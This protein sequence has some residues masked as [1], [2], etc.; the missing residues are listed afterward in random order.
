MKKTTYPCSK[1][2]TDLRN[3]YLE[4]EPRFRKL[5]D[6][7]RKHRALMLYLE[8]WRRCKANP[9][10]ATT[11]LRKSYAE[12]YM[13]ENTVPNI[14][15][16]ELIVGKPDLRD[17]TPE[18]TELFAKYME[19]NEFVV[20][21]WGRKDH[22]A[23]DYQLLLDEGV[24]G[25]LEILK[26]E[27]EKIN[28][29]DGMQ[30]ERYEFLLC[31]KIELEGVVKLSEAYADRALEMAESLVGEE[32][33]EMMELYRVLKQVPANPARTF[34][35]ALQSIQMFTFNLYGLYSYGKPDLYLYPYYARDIENGVLTP[36]KAQEL[37]DCFY[38]LSVPNCPSWAAMGLM[39]GGRDRE[40]NSI[41]N[42]LTWHFLNAIE[43]TGVPDPNIGFCV[44]EETGKEILEYVAEIISK[45]YAQPQIWNTD[46]VIESMVANG[47]DRK[48]ANL[49][50][51]STCVEVTP[52]GCSGINVTSP[53]INVLKV[54]LDSF[55]KCDN[56]MSFDD[57]F[58][59]FA[60]C[61][62]DFCR[63][64]VT[65]ENLYLLEQGRNSTD[66]VRCSLLIHDCLERGKTHD[67][68]GA[69]YNQLE[70]DLFGI[71]NVGESLNV[72]KK[73][74]FKEKRISVEELKEALKKDFAGYENL[75][76]YIRNKVPH[77][78]SGDAE[79]N[80]IM[81]KVSDLMLEVFENKVTARNDGILPGNFSYLYHVR[82]G[83][84]T[85]ASP[86]GRKSGMPLND[87]C[88]PVQG[89]DDK[90]PTLSLASTVYWEPSRFLGGT[91]VNIKLNKS[92]VP[93]KI[94]A[95]IRGYLKT[96]GAQLQ[97]SV[98]SAEDLLNAQKSPE[99][100]KDIL[101]RIGGYSEFFVKLNK[102]QQDEIISRT[103]HEI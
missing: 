89:Y 52:I 11:R 71:S 57:I 46:A 13:L 44:T 2:V 1:R 81:K 93:E 55:D 40:G 17:F 31:A 91:S 80:E 56:N 51:L 47:F 5:I 97:F 19:A 36:E 6:N 35:E 82:R 94:V 33:D 48:D 100:Y 34:R 8:G 25:M 61:F 12:K 87:G 68:G 74:V 7:T 102:S 9:L 69:R 18:E 39:L 26:A 32:K 41:E 14:S 42:E 21:N 38:L 37:I 73:V 72:I 49:F 76:S 54:F 45:G 83:K 58:E 65:L 103:L 85:P 62:S 53:M 63:E 86:D 99:Q 79:A 84:E 4:D 3:Y 22:V 50:T 27:I 96:N 70:P 59:T 67:S 15:P 64:Q 88:N 30:A 24:T 95:L 60:K 101:V 28:F 75:L 92:V 29:D 43:H 66:P 90:G 16:G 23:L 20:D 78:G 98:V 10:V 77:F